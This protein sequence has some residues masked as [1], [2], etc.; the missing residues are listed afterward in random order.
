MGGSIALA[1]HPP[2]DA[3]S[4]LSTDFKDT[5]DPWMRLVSACIEAA[6]VGVIVVGAIAASVLFVAGGL[7]SKGWSDAF[8][9]YRANLGRA[10]LLG[11]EL[12][13]AADIVGTVA[14]TPSFE[15]LGVLALIVLIRTF[16]SLSLQLE[17]E[18][19]WPW[20]RAAVEHPGAPQDRL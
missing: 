1:A 3:L 4:R 6:G 17:I 20:H 10:I 9:L 2:S 18:G 15:N 7:G 5:L 14:V 19:H 12:L 11:L 13:V 16:L 8:R